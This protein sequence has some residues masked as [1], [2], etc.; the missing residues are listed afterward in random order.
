MQCWGA[1]NK[2]DIKLLEN[3][4]RMV[5]GLE[6]KLCEEAEVSLST[7]S[8]EE[9]TGGRRHCRLHL[10]DEEEGQTLISSLW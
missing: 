8:G 4:Q 5:K 2:K 7:H 9:E 1:Q 10:P 6:G 3:V